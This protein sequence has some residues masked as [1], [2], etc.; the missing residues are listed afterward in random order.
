MHFSVS[1]I[2]RCQEGMFEYRNRFGA[3][4]DALN[5][6]FKGSGAPNVDV[7]VLVKLD[8]YQAEMEIS[9]PCLLCLINHQASR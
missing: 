9:Q 1:N 6:A 5:W 3:M 4:V 8:G 7:I 2:E